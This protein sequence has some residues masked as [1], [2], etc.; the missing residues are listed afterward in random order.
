M[1]TLILAAGRGKN[2]HPL[3]D[4]RP[5]PMIKICNKPILHYLMDLLVKSGIHEVE[6]V[7]GHEGKK[8]LDYFHY[9]QDFGVTINY[10][11]QKEQSGI[12]EAVL[13]ARDKFA[14][15]DYFMLI[16]GDIFAQDN[17]ISNTLMSFHA[18]KHPVATICLTPTPSLF[19]NIYMTQDMK[20]TK[21]VEKPDKSM[22]NYVLAGVFIL[23]T[24]FFSTLE[25]ANHD[26]EQAFTKLLTD[27]GLYAT[28][29]EE[30]WIDL[31]YP[32]DILTANQI[33]MG[34]WQQT[35]ID[36]SVSMTGNV[37]IEGPVRIDRNVTIESGTVIKGP[38][39]IGPDCYIGNNV[40]IRQN[41]SIGQ[42][43]VIGFGVEIKNSVL[44]GK[45]KVGRLS[46][47][48]DS[49]IGEN[50]IIGSGVMTVNTDLDRSPIEVKLFDCRINSHLQKLG[51]FIGD[52]VE[53]GAS[54][55]L[56]FGTIVSPNTKVKGNF[57]ISEER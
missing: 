52:N 56:K 45:N 30:D 31:G 7:I 18:L 2:L 48:G 21:I 44:F 53:I 43:S 24:S 6:V 28:I 3:T 27:T 41:S 1:K 37:R 39:Y 5:K 32:W 50:T 40:L 19:G 38:C 47:I 34:S 8:I 20:I 26:I 4:T 33:V 57:S 17:L 49:V 55:T 29:W 23:P 54:N 36:E 16:Y 35:H 46:F 9:G 15:S 14:E 42:G 22:G 25:A 51:A 10:L 12:G 11:H 13:L